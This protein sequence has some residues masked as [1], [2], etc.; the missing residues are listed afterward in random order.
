[1]ADYNPRQ[2]KH[3]R[4]DLVFIVQFLGA[5]VLADDESVFTDFVIWLRDLLVHRGVSPDVLASGLNTLQP[6][7]QDVHSGASALLDAGRNQL[8]AAPA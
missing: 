3:T 5:A 2:L 4:E 1:M 6:L 8:V 7:V